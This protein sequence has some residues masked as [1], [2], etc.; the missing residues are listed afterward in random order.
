MKEINFLNLFILH[1][2]SCDWI[3]RQ[4]LFRLF[5][6][7]KRNGKYCL[8]ITSKIWI[9]SVKQMANESIWLDAQLSHIVGHCDRFGYSSMEATIDGF[10]NLQSHADRMFNA[11]YLYVLWGRVVDCGIFSFSFG[12]GCGWLRNI[13]TKM[14]N[15]VTITAI[16][17]VTDSVRGYLWIKCGST[18]K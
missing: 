7:R 18:N 9:I 8:L 16:V 11:M 14:E 6:R 13:Q 10:S 2:M 15:A 3:Q 17:F 4:R 1:F 5:L 12:C